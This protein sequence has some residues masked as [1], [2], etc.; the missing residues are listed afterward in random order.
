MGF[1]GRTVMVEWRELLE[2]CGVPAPS[3]LAA[4][5]GRY[6]EL[7]RE[8]NRVVSLV[9][10]GDLDRLDEHVADSLSLAP[11]VQEACGEGG[12]LLDIG[13]GGGFPG[14]PLACAL[15]GVRV[16]LVERSDR[17]VGFLRQVVG[18]LKLDNAE[19]I[20]G[21]FPLAAAGLVPRAVTA[22]AVEKPA[23]VLRDIGRFLPEEAVFLCQVGD[24]RPFLGETFHVERVRDAWTEAGARRGE[25]YRVRR[26]VP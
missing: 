1:D 18:G 9:S 15:P 5:M 7:I 4:R 12:G 23:K 17:K 24:P 3:D 13:S 26:S 20:C 21:E 8:W 2:G 11:Y 6:C 22:R 14:V 25:L 10:H 16:A 19:V